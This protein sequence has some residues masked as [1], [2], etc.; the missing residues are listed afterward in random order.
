M[1]IFLNRQDKS[2]KEM[3]VPRGALTIANFKYK[4]IQN[5]LQQVSWGGYV[6]FELLALRQRDSAS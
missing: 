2:S 1:A 4:V 6:Y 5:I 3:K